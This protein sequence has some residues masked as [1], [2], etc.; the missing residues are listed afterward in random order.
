MVVQYWTQGKAAKQKLLL[1]LGPHLTSK[2]LVIGDL[3]I[4]VELTEL[5]FKTNQELFLFSAIEH[6]QLLNR[7][8]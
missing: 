6:L 2:S 5:C 4:L 1:S 3:S 8:N 7:S